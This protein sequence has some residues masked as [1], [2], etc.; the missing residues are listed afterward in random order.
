M[1]FSAKLNLPYVL[2]NQAQ[3]HLTV[4]ESL[5]ALDAL[6]QL[7]VISL[8]ETAPPEA[9]QEGDRYIVGAEA[10]GD[11]AGADGMIVS[12]QRGAWQ[13]YTPQVGWQAW[14]EASDSFVVFNGAAWVSPSQRE[15][16]SELGIN[17]TADTYNRLA[18]RAPASLFDHEGAGHQLKINKADEGETASVVFQSGYSGRAELGLNGNDNLSLNVSADGGSFQNAVTV[19]GDTGY[20]GI[21]T[22]WPTAALH[23]EGVFK[24]GV[25][26]PEALPGAAEVGVGAVVCLEGSTNQ[27]AL[28]TSDGKNW[29]RIN[30]G[31]A[32]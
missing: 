22:N 15:P 4:N 13:R 17:A 2:P 30:L 8:T 10:S 23:V 16:I 28:A 26:S 31:V 19:R 20:V 5:S 7:S 11:W 12:Y 29:F 27:I 24:L 1:D 21:G 18:L 9:P 3:K 32:L 6:V 14:V 25:F